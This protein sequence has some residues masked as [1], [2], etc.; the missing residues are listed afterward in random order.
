MVV[1]VLGVLAVTVTAITP[2]IFV[3]EQPEPVLFFQAEQQETPTEIYDS[4]SN[5]I[6]SHYFDLTHKKNGAVIVTE[7]RENE[8]LA[9][10]MFAITGTAGNQ[11]FKR[12]SS[13][14]DWTWNVETHDLNLAWGIAQKYFLTANNKQ[15]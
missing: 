13:D 14:F 4:D 11:N 6:H 1:L 15:S 12:F 7:N 2:L 9:S 10:L 5:T 3:D 8:K